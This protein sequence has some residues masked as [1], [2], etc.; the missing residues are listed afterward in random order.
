MAVIHISEA[1]AARD[2]HAVL[3]KVRAGEHV[4]IDSLGDSITLLP[5]RY[6][7]PKT[8]TLSEAIRLSEERGS[9]VLL[10]DQLGEDLEAII[11]QHENEYVTNLWE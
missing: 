3:A 2:F 8:R 1:E 5:S 11:K 4:Q 7:V 9:N 10:D 6:D